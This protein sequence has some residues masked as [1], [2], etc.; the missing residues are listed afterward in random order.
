M[1]CRAWWRSRPAARRANRYRDFGADQPRE[2]SCIVGSEPEPPKGQAAGRDAPARRAERGSC[3]PSF[4][5][6]CCNRRRQD[7]GPSGSPRAEGHG[8]P[9]PSGGA[10]WM[11]RRPV[12][13][14]KSR[15]PAAC[16]RRAPKCATRPRPWHRCPSDPTGRAASSQ[17]TRV[18]AC[19]SRTAASR[20]R[21]RDAQAAHRGRRFAV[22]SPSR[23]WVAAALPV[24][25]MLRPARP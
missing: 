1:T 24:H 3:A 15:G 22:N 8:T 9:R 5:T 20:A 13:V 11:P 14:A 17:G 7:I 12:S 18:A 4:S 16:G 2:P 21:W 19:S 23:L 10:L 6:Q 25:W